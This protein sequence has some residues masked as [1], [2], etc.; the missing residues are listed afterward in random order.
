MKKTSVFGM[1]ALACVSGSVCA[2]DE[3]KAAAAAAPAAEVKAAPAAE[4]VEAE[5]L[6]QVSYAFGVQIFSGM[7]SQGVELDTDRF[8][9]GMAE[10]AAGKASMDLAQAQEVLNQYREIAARKMRKKFETQGAGNMEAGKKYLEENGKKDGVTTTATGLQYEV[11]KAA[12]GAKPGPTDTVNVHY[13]GMLTDGSV[14]DSSVDRGQPIS[15]PLNGVIP[16]WTEGVQLMS[17]GSKFKFTI[18]GNLAY[19]ERGSPPKIGPN[20]VLVFEVE[21]LGIGD[22]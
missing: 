10:Q 5:L 21:L 20:A 2:Q 12:E 13:H 3:A 1:L 7:K 8:S 22:K 15:F 4:V 16:G 11:L 18:P 9:A 6:K 14:F 17:V 19:G